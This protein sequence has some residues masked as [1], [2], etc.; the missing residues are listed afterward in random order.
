MPKL[1][2]AQVKKPITEFNMFERKKSE[3]RISSYSFCPVGIIFL[4]L[5]IA[6]TFFIL[7]CCTP[8]NNIQEISD[9]KVYFGITKNHPNDCNCNDPV[10]RKIPK[11]AKM[12]EAVIL[13]LEE[14]IKGPSKEESAQG[15]GG[16]MPSG[17]LIA[18]YKNGYMK[19]VKA[20]QESGKI[21]EWGQRFLNPIGEFTPWGD[22]V[23]VISVQI[24]DSIAYTDFSKELYSYG[25][26]SCRVEAIETAIVN[27]VMQ[28]PNIKKVL[29]LI[30]GKRAELQP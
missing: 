9:V 11:T 28:F 10:V 4:V 13:A 3:F 8:R 5:L 23:R 27:T 20:S 26:G 18:E 1:S 30:E 7:S 17:I 16:C 29:I 19:M 2:C 25:G 22:R 6:G 21:D 24:K 15:Y 14:L 12:E